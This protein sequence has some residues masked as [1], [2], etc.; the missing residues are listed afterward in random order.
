[1]IKLY[2]AIAFLLAV[3]VLPPLCFAQG[4]KKAE[5][6]PYQSSVYGD[7]SNLN[8]T[9]DASVAVPAGKQLAVE[10]VSLTLA[11]SSSGVP[12][13]TTCQILGVGPSPDYTVRSHYLN[14]HERSNGVDGVL[15][16]ASDPVKMYLEDGSTPQITCDLGRTGISMQLQGWISGQLVNTQ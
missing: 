7:S 11:L 8:V 12:Y 16:T 2:S 10:Y 1:M 6:I 3:A 15:F 14:L 4:G 5:P 13:T 9:A